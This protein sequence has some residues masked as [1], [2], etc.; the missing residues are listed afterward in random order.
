MLVLYI[1]DDP[2][3]V[4]MVTKMLRPRGYTVCSAGDARQGLR[5]AMQ[6]RPD[7]ILMDYNLPGVNGLDAVMMLRGS[8]QLK[9]IPVV[10]VTAHATEQEAQYF[11]QAGCDD[12]LAK[13]VTSQR[14]VS[15]IE[16]HIKGCRSV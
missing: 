10:M 9:N 12:F 13:P 7:L 3:A 16:K 8:T 14:L 1:E 5:M 2:S 6:E 15:T 4:R 11:L